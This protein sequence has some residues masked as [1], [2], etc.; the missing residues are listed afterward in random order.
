[1]G[2]AA[3]PPPTGRI[4]LLGTTYP[5]NH[6]RR[7]KVPVRLKSVSDGSRAQ[8]SHLLF[9]TSGTVS[10]AHDDFS[11][12]LAQSTNTKSHCRFTGPHML[13]TFR[14]RTFEKPL[15][16]GSTRRSRYPPVVPCFKLVLAT[17]STCEVG[18][19]EFEIYL[20]SDR[21]LSLTKR[22]MH[23]SDFSVVK[24][25]RDSPRDGNSPKESR[26][27]RGGTFSRRY[28]R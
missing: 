22:F 21:G 7:G 13:C 28:R 15:V 27:P 24:P 26:R 25:T 16:V 10:E 19:G 5:G 20:W 2:T 17:T 8:V 1:V 14:V 6:P 9:R 23:L 12:V 3:V 18:V 4:L 11:L